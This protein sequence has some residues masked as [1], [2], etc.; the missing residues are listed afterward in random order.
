[1][2]LP[3]SHTACI[4]DKRRERRLIY[5]VT[6]VE[7]FFFFLGGGMQLILFY[8]F[9]EYMVDSLQNWMQ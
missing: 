8:L 7:G 4:F 5:L 9:Y 1:M 3:C 6:Y 2:L